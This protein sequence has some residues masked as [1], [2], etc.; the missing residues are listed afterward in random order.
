MIFGDYVMNGQEKKQ[1]C[2]SIMQT[3]DAFV[4]EWAHNPLR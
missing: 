3:V 2:E 4:E 1:I